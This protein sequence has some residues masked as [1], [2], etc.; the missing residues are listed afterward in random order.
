MQKRSRLLSAQAG[1]RGGKHM[2]VLTEA[3]RHTR[4]GRGMP[5]RRDRH[6]LS[7]LELRRASGDSIAEV[8]CLDR[9]SCVSAHGPDSVDRN[10]RWKFPRREHSIQADTRGDLQRRILLELQHTRT[11][12]E[13]IR[14]HQIDCFACGHDFP[15]LRQQRICTKFRPRGKRAI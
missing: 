13:I 8:T 7:S 4:R 14:S 12:E 9:V 3:G 10:G 5:R 11:I 15:S 6:T 2:Q 1:H